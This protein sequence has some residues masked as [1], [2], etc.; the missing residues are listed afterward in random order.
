M[1]ICTF[2]SSLHDQFVIPQT[3]IGG[4]PQH[5]EISTK[6]PMREKCVKRP[7]KTRE[8]TVKNPWTS[9]KNLYAKDVCFFHFFIGV[10][11]A[12]KTL[13][14]GTSGKSAIQKAKERAQLARKGSQCEFA[15]YFA[16][17]P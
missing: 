6:N 14:M 7:W 3:Y 2:C 12:Q 13:A 15:P 4:S 17:W 10:Q 11:P 9:S 5:C 16:T 8:T 1:L